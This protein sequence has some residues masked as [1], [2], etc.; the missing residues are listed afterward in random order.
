ML[1]LANLPLE[2]KNL[3]AAHVA[4]LV[5][6]DET[7]TSSGGDL[8]SLRLVNHEWSELASQHYWKV[9]LRRLSLPLAP[10]PADPP[11]LEQVAKLDYRS[12]ADLTT[13]LS[14]ILPQQAHHIRILTF[15]SDHPIPG[16]TNT[17]SSPAPALAAA[18][19]ELSHRVDLV[20]SIMRGLP[21]LVDV[22]LELGIN[23][24]HGMNDSCLLREVG[25]Q[26]KVEKVYLS[27]YEGV[28]LD[29]GEVALLLGQLPRLR[30]LNLRDVQ[31]G[32]ELVRALRGLPELEV[33]QLESVDE[34]DVEGLQA[35]GWSP[36]LRTLNSYE[37]PTLPSLSSF[38][39]LAHH[40]SS[41]LQH[42]AYLP[43][44]LGALP[45]PA[46]EQ[47]RVQLPNLRTLHLE[48]SLPPSVFLPSL[49]PCHQLTS[50]VVRFTSPSTS[51]GV[52]ETLDAHVLPFV[53]QHA[54]L[55][56]CTLGFV[57]QEG[58]DVGEEVVDRWAGEKGVSGVVESEVSGVGW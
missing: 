18:P 22:D 50:L 23:A 31:G 30:V 29:E 25:R 15:G 13:F 44:S 9:Y 32:K 53:Q 56:K 6:Q 45:P 27:G 35:E 21:R 49:T 47:E 55:Q 4:S 40:F 10:S 38:L 46:Q 57:D 1:S 41:T 3:I 37:C 17:D 8:G 20:L 7:L 51:L 48:T 5:P 28:P 11:S 42:V 14:L 43:P 33:L 24:A 16:R 12:S 54:E 19:E 26:G 39:L 36:P 34:M 52:L 58:A 2:I